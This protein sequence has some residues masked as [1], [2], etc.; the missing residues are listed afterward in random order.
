[1]RE[2]DLARPRIAAAADQRDRRRGVMRRTQRPPTPILEPKAAC[3]RVDRGGLQCLVLGHRRQQ[4]G[5][6]LRKHRLARSGRA[7]HDQ[8]VAAGCGDFERAL[9]TGLSA[10]IGEIVR[11]R[12]DGGR[13]RR[14]ET[15]ER[16]AAGDVRTHGE[17]ALG[18]MHD[19]VFHQ[20]SLGGARFR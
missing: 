9:R 12:I 11:H 16:L 6:P 7:E 3:E 1:M 18:R 5:Q 2:R 15:R 10:H 8:A 14:N 13:S 20:R 19:R 17:E 4:P